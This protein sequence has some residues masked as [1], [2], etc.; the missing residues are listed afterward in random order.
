[1]EAVMKG[2][3]VGA[4]LCVLSLSAVDLSA[5]SQDERQIR[6]AEEAMGKAIAEGDV[7]SYDKL[8]ADDFQFITGAGAIVTKADRLALLKKGP[9]S[10]FVTAPD[11]IRV[12]GDVAVVTGRQGIGRAVRYTRVWVRQKGGWRAVATQA[13]AIAQPK[14]QG[15]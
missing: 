3:L 15:R 1:M 14:P 11:S 4:V 7:A 10:G 8:A 12:Y 2:R 6:A 5:Q 9:T 13:T